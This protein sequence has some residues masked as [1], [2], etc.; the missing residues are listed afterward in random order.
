MSD[1]VQQQVSRSGSPRGAPGRRVTVPGADKKKKRDQGVRGGLLLAGLLLVILSGGAFW[2]ILQE[3]DTRQEYLVTV[4]PIER[5]EVVGPGHFGVVAANIG[6]AEGVPPEFVDVLVGKWAAG[7]IPANTIVTPGLFQS[8]PLSGA[9]E[10]DKV[11][12]EV[13]LPAGEAPGGS[14]ASGDKIALFGAESSEGGQAGSP[15]LIGVLELPSVQG[16]VIRYVV[17]PGEAQAIQGI[18]GRYN[19]AADRR[20]WKVGFDL[21]AEELID[22][23]R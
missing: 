3:M 5:F 4:R 6:T 21:S 18:V 23:A 7:S 2:Y 20:M 10:A 19:A 15:T 1:V 8:P 9:E 14:L 11:L 13:S 22:A 12:I 17:T 16:N